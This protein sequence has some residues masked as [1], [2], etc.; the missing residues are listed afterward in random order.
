MVA[1]A[2]WIEAVRVSRY[3]KAEGYW[4]ARS[5]RT[6]KSPGKKPQVQKEDSRRT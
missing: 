4:M 2:G 5:R 3:G 6:Y 1:Q